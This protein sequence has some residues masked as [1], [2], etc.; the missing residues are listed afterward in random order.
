MSDS[1]N[2]STVNAATASSYLEPGMYRLKVDA[3]NTKVFTPEGK[4]AYLSVKFVTENGASVTEKFFLTAKA[5]PRLQY[6]HEAWFNKKLDKQFKTYPEVGEYFRH[7]LTLKIVSRPMIVGGKVNA[8][9]KFF[10]GLPYS[11]FVVADEGLF[12]EGA[13]EKDS[14]RYK[15]VVQVEKPNPAVANNNAA[16]LPDSDLPSTGGYQPM[17]DTNSPW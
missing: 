14:A 3:A 13:F 10:A 8:D 17:D 16:L 15:N 12:E 5:L 4:T 6:L 2:F 11:G 7:A 9:G 1:I